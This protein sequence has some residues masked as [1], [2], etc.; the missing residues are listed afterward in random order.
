MSPSS[1]TY[2]HQSCH[3]TKA[4]VSLN[5]HQRR[6]TCRVLRRE[7]WR[8]ACCHQQCAAVAVECSLWCISATSVKFPLRKCGKWWRIRLS[9][10]RS[11]QK[12]WRASVEDW[13]QLELRTPCEKFLATPLFD[14]SALCQNSY[15]PTYFHVLTVYWAHRHDHT[16]NSR[17][18]SS[19]NSPEVEFGLWVHGLCPFCSLWLAVRQLL[20]STNV[21]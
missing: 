17:L 21:A 20:F 2:F 16:S 19:I 5:W 10:F 9:K 6:Q 14:F 1:G 11:R 8:S 3:V 15:A 18:T 4:C 12:Q 7:S 13:S